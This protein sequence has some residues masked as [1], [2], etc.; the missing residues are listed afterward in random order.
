MQV[1]ALGPVPLRLLRRQH[2]FARR[3]GGGQVGVVA[4][5]LVRLQEEE[6]RTGRAGLPLD[7]LEVVL[8]LRVEVAAIA[9]LAGKQVRPGVEHSV[10]GAISLQS[11]DKVEIP[12]RGVLGP[13]DEFRGQ[14]RLLPPEP[15]HLRN[16]DVADLDLVQ[17]RPGRLEHRLRVQTPRPHT[18]VI[19]STQ[20]ENVEILDPQRRLQTPRRHLAVHGQP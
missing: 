17:D 9:R 3:Q 4:Q 10:P 5:S 13:D 14:V 19:G 6:A 11:A 18:P 2:P 1:V 7:E 15:D 16:R 20:E 12:A 8:Q